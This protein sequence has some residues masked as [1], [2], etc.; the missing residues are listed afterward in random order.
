VLF[1]LYFNT[2]EAA[3]VAHPYKN[4]SSP[5]IGKGTQG[6][7]NFLGT[8]DGL[9]EILLFVFTLVDPLEEPGR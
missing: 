9:L 6:S 5:R 1:L 2:T 3:V 7:G 8:A 4:A